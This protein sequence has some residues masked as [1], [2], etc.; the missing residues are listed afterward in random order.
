M[1]DQMEKR[2]NVLSN[3]FLSMRL[4]N[5]HHLVNIID[6]TNDILY[7][8]TSLNLIC[9]RFVLWK[10]KKKKRKKNC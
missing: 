6:N 3:F 9:Y 7:K 8:N 5:T 10:K 4:K 2:W 1:I